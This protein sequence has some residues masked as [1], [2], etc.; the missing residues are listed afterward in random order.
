MTDQNSTLRWV[1]R[2]LGVFGKLR[3]VGSQPPCFHFSLRHSLAPQNSLPVNGTPIPS[4][5][6]LLPW[7]H[8]L[9]IFVTTHILTA[10]MSDSDGSPNLPI[11]STIAQVTKPRKKTAKPSNIGDWYSQVSSRFVDLVGDYA[12]KETFLVE[13]DSLLLECFSD[14]RIDFDGMSVRK[15]KS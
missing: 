3:S 13:G 15:S 12:G 14:P 7:V 9:S 4:P 6:S 10:T 8:S 2:D 5:P 1:L 11:R